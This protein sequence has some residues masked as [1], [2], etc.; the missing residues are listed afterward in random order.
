MTL[1]L[2]SNLGFVW[3]TNEAVNVPAPGGTPGIEYAAPQHDRHH[4]AN[5]SA[6]QM[7]TAQ[8]DRHFSAPPQ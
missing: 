1:L 2:V 6:R 3:G 7:A 8:H 4:A 5:P